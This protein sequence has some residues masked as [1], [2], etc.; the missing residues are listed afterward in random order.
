MEELL[1]LFQN[2]MQFPY[3][4]I[5]IPDKL[6]LNISKIF[7]NKFINPERMMKEQIDMVVSHNTLTFKDLYVE[8]ASIVPR[9]KEILYPFK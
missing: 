9:V 6:Y 2:V 5:R 8:P 4:A 3:R 7:R 1:E